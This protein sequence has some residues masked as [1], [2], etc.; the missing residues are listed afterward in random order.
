MA[1]AANYFLNKW[2]IIFRQRQK[3]KVGLCHLKY[4]GTYGTYCN[5]QS[6]EI[7]TNSLL[8]HIKLLLQTDDPH[9]FQNKECGML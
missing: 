2:T 1:T 9:C 8:R 6:N 7:E 3:V 5:N 4:L